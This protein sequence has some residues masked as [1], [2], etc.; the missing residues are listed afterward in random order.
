MIMA[1][2]NGHTDNLK[3]PSYNKVYN[4]FNKLY[5]NIINVNIPQKLYEMLKIIQ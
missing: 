1:I 2:L 3:L 5:E 4:N